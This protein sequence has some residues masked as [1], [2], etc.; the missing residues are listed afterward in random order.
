MTSR[1]TQK[2]PAHDDAVADEATV[3]AFPMRMIDAWNEGD[4]AAFAAPFSDTADFIA[5]DGT[6]LK[7]KREIAAFH[8]RLFDTELKGTHLE[9]EVEFV[10]LL[11]PDVAVLHARGGTFLAGCDY[12]NPSRESMQ[13]FVAVRHGGEWRVEALLNARK[14]TLEQQVFADDFESLAVASQRAIK[15]RVRYL[16][17]GLRD[18]TTDAT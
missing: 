11:T 9:G 1:S 7:G 12:A 4:G 13:I 5:F 2:K 6:H 8:Q 14:L 16:R 18:T 15:D 10:R 3:R 17:D